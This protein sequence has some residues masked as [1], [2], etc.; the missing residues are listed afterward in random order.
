MYSDQSL[1]LKV[2]M[3]CVSGASL[4]VPPWGC[5]YA[6]GSVTHSLTLAISFFSFKTSVF[7]QNFCSV[8]VMQHDICKL[9]KGDANNFL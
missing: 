8:L 1:G 5:S 4:G 6:K 3:M 2:Q 9:S 7:F